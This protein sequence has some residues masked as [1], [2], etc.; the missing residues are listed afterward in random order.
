MTLT[1]KDA[2]SFEI[3]SGWT[4]GDAECER[5]IDVYLDLVSTVLALVLNIVGATIVPVGGGL[6]NSRE[7]VSAL[8]ERV[9]AKML[10]RS[11]VPLLVPAQLTVNPAF[12]GAALLGFQGLG[13]QGLG[14]QGPK[15]G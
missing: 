10:Y 15:R 7:L 6:A 12:I 3:V 2:S 13:F 11:P 1:G 8:D 4:G 5:V 9:R 14:F